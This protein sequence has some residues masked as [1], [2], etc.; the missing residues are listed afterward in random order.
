[1][2]RLLASPALRRA[3]GPAL[4][5]R[6]PLRGLRGFANDYERGSAWRYR[7]YVVRSSTPT[8]RTTASCREQIAGD[9][10]DPDDPEMLVAVGFL[11]MGRGNSPAWKC[12]KSPGSGFSM[13]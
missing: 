3:D 5:R 1:M 12:Q 4:A 9:E 11:R 8:S 7:D 6:R 2:D 10:I 13:T